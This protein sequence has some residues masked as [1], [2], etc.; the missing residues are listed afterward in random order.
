M[1][2]AFEKTKEAIERLKIDG[3][4]LRSDAERQY[5]KELYSEGRSFEEIAK[6]IVTRRQDLKPDT[7]QVWLSPGG[8]GYVL[9]RQG[10]ISKDD[11]IQYYAEHYENI[12]KER[13]KFQTVRKKVL[14]RDNY[15]CQV[16]GSSGQMEVDH[17]VSLANKGINEPSNCI[18]LCKKHHSMKTKGVR[19]HN[20]FFFE[21]YE[22]AAKKIGVS[23]KFEF[24]KYCKTHHFSVK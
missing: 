3:G 8:I 22:K 12:R 17:I 13:T 6:A 10:L 15:K 21:A 23:G 16:C 5:L 9:V 4:G 1:P 20:K 11:L 7:Q 14:E 2:S 18:T 19:G 24:C